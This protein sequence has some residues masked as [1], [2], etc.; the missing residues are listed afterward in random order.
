M[1]EYRVETRGFSAYQMAFGPNLVH[2]YC[3]KSDGSDFDCAQDASM[4]RLFVQRRRLR[5][6]AQE[7]A[8][9][10]MAMCELRPPLAHSR[11][12]DRADVMVG[13]VRSGAA[14]ASRRNFREARLRLRSL[15]RADEWAG[16][17]WASWG[18]IRPL[19][20][21]MGW[22]FGHPR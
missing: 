7:A 17:M 6:I 20:V 5:V 3:R 2:L 9:R 1:R 19:G 10:E 13:G 4:P 22:R 21:L 16:S 14:R 18:G 12:F 8:S 11:S 15:V